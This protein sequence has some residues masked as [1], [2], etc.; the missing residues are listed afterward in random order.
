MAQHED[1]GILGPVPATA[2]HQQVDL[3]PDKTVEAE[4][5]PALILI[6]AT[7]TNQIETRRERKTEDRPAGQL[8]HGG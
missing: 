2:Q 7:R 8:E 5:G 6:D 4:A 3:E 1:F